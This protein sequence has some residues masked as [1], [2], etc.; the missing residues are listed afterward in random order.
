[1][2]EI[3]ADEFPALLW[4]RAFSQKIPMEA[5]GTRMLIAAG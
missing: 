4:Q 2:L 1:M 3:E 5:S